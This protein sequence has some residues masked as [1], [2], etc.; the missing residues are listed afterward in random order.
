MKFSA[1]ILTRN[2]EKNIL[3]C[4]ECVKMADEIIIVDD[5]SN[6]RT[7]EVI[8]SL[9]LENIR[10][11]QRHLDL[12]FASQRNFGLSKAKNEWVLFIDADERVSASLLNEIKSLSEDKYNGYFIQR[13]DVIWGKELNY[14]ETGN[15]KFIRLAKKSS[16]KWVGKVHEK[17]MIKGEAGVLR[18]KVLHFP[19]QTMAEFISEINFYSTLRADELHKKNTTVNF[20]QIVLYPKSKF[21]MNYILKLGILDGLPGL[22]MAIM[23]SLH[24]FL[25]RSKLWLLNNKI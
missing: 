14:G 2:E 11:Q 20:I 12:D 15:I 8:E 19:H 3:D 1:V 22:N 21:I 13:R 17:W 24:S 5:Y 9:K 7:I 4:I 10:I 25:V 23:M 18:N 16:G 6:D